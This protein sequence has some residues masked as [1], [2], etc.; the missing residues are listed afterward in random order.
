[1]NQNLRAKQK[2]SKELK[3][4]KKKAISSKNVSMQEVFDELI[5]MDMHDT[6]KLTGM[7]NVRN[8]LGQFNE[9]PI[10]LWEAWAEDIQDVFTSDETFKEESACFFMAVSCSLENTHRY[11]YGEESI[12]EEWMGELF[13]RWMLL[14][15]WYI[16]LREESDTTK[17]D[18]VIVFDTKFLMNMDIKSI[19]DE[20]LG[21]YEKSDANEE[22]NFAVF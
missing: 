16:A 4:K 8:P 15:Q 1:M 2:H 13:S 21:L 6:L 12:D 9:I 19:E 3:R 11:L 22:E 20:I 5:D 10:E 7:W 17:L 18:D 14:V